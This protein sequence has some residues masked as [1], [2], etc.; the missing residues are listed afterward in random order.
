MIHLAKAQAQKGSACWNHE[1]FTNYFT[2]HKSRACFSPPS[3]MTLK[4]PFFPG[5]LHLPTGGYALYRCAEE[6]LGSH[7]VQSEWERNYQRPEQ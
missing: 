1:P 5:Q 3:K 7:P 4:S 6:L 2:E